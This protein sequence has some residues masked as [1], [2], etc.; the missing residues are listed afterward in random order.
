MKYMHNKLGMIVEVTRFEDGF[1]WFITNGIEDVMKEK[2]FHEN[3]MA[4]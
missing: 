1:V 3:Y 2:L 4:L